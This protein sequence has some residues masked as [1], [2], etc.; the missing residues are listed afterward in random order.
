[1]LAYEITSRDFGT[2]HVYCQQCASGKMLTA[3]SCNLIYK[4]SYITMVNDL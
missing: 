2:M 3:E 4:D 1:M